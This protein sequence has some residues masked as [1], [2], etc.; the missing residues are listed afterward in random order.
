MSGHGHGDSHPVAHGPS[1]SHPVAHGDSHPHEHEHRGGLR[2]RV[3]SLIRPHSHDASDSVDAALESSAVGIRA[4]KISLVVLLLTALA[5][6]AVV[7]VTGSVALLADTIHNFSDALTALPLW[8]AFALGRRPPS[9]RY[10]YGYGRAE[11]LAGVSS[12]S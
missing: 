10:T 11:D 3:A 8:I 1:D 4:L 7:L 6:A 5:Q 9:R 2:G 12:S